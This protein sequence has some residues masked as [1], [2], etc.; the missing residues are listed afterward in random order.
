MIQFENNINKLLDLYL[1]KKCKEEQFKKVKEWIA[2]SPENQEYFLR[3]KA[4]SDSKRY[5]ALLEDNEKSWQ[6][7]LDKLE[8]RKTA[9]VE[10]SPKFTLRK[11]LPYAAAIVL[12]LSVAYNFYWSATM[13]QECK[14]A[15]SF[16]EFST[17]VGSK[18]ALITLSD[19]TKVELNGSSKITYPSHFNGQYREVY[20]EGEAYFDVAHNAEKP[21]IVTFCNH[22]VEVLGT[23][24]NIE[25]YPEL[26]YIKTTLFTGSIDLSTQ[27]ASLHYSHRL[28]PNQ[29]CIYNKESKEH[30]LLYTN[31]SLIEAW[32]NGL[33][34]F[35][36][37]SLK[38][39]CAKL[40]LH[41]GARIDLAPQ[42]SKELYTGSISLDNSLLTA[43]ELLNYKKEFCIRATDESSYKITN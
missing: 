39:I 40:A 12:L 31:V 43:L 37:A 34:K 36:D 7:L 28:T 32:R 33:Y 16:T 10:V 8:K 6:R 23:S 2:K 30:Q 41:Y 19:G 26:D 17:P 35:K 13:E 42:L 29:T 18:P 3:Y 20:L 22:K 38:D 4:I 14:P 24:F 9:K 11:Y 1:A 5:G 25:A 15:L 27:E 21:F